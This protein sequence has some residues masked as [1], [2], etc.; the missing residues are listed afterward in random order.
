MLM[1]LVRDKRGD[2]IVEV[3]I[4]V[5]IVSLVLAGAYASTSRSARATLDAQ[6]HSQALRAVESQLEYLRANGKTAGNDVCFTPTGTE[7]SSGNAAC[8]VSPY[9]PGTQPNYRLQIFQPSAGNGQAY[10]VQAT[11]PSSLDGTSKVSMFYRPPP[12]N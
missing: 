1:K 11:W 7:V 6:E 9:G 3:L 10:E 4:A 12:G 5:S 8:T 2:T